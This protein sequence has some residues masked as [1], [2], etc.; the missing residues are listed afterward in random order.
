MTKRTNQRAGQGGT[1]PPPAPKRGM[2]IWVQWGN[3]YSLG[4]SYSINKV[5]TRSFYVSGNGRQDRYLLVEW[6]QWLARRFAEGKVFLEGK[7]LAAPPTLSLP[8]Q[9][10][11]AADA[12][13]PVERDR[14]FFRA[15]RE[16]LGSY[17]IERVA[18]GP[19]EVEYL[20]T[21]GT[22]SYRIYLRTDWSTP[23]R[24]T[25]PDART[26]SGEPG[27]AFCKHSIAVLLQDEAHRGQLLE[28]LL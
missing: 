10:A 18:D 17:D 23:P 5:N 26:R 28:L 24:C 8:P 6:D 13:D 1:K 3:Y 25:C 22:D 15:A 16:V 14:R 20:I 19:Q 12:V 9:V 4:T 27:G 7:L 11:E 21:G 2:N